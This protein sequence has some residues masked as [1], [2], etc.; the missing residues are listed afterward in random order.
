MTGIKRRTL[1]ILTGSK[2]AFKMNV[3]PYTGADAILIILFCSSDWIGGCFAFFIFY[4]NGIWSQTL[5]FP[6]GLS[7]FQ[8]MLFVKV[9]YYFQCFYSAGILVRE[10]PLIN[11]TDF[12]SSDHAIFAFQSCFRKIKNVSLFLTFHSQGGTGEILKG[13]FDFIHINTL[14]GCF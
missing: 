2:L 10:L 5:Y 1:G 11:D 14:F 9:V 7:Y 4:G 12:I 13:S 3:Y 6:I 8:L